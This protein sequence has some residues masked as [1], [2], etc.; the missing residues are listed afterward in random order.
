MRS[1][2]RRCCNHIALAVLQHKVGVVIIVITSAADEVHRSVDSAVLE[3]SAMTGYLGVLVGE[4]THVLHDGLVS[5]IDSHCYPFE[6]YAVVVKGV[7]HRQV[8]QIESGTVA[9][10]KYRIADIFSLSVEDDAITALTDKRYIVAGE[11]HQRFFSAYLLTKVVLTILDED[12]LACGCSRGIGCINIGEG[13]HQFIDSAYYVVISRL[14]HSFGRYLHRY[15]DSRVGYVTVLVFN[16]SLSNGQRV[17][18][19]VCQVPCREVER[20]STALS[21]Y[22]IASNLSG[23]IVGYHA[24]EGQRN[25]SVVVVDGNALSPLHRRGSRILMGSGQL[26][27]TQGLAGALRERE[28]NRL[29]RLMVL[30]RDNE[31]IR[32]TLVG[33]PAVVFGRDIGGSPLGGNGD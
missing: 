14:Y 33:V 30:Y 13:L 4:H 21:R 2:G 12:G 32:T 25:H 26:E 17:V 15:L 8:L 23:Y 7:L 5:S 16:C 31:V 29:T 3:I 24:V 6:G 19:C 28:R 22:R 10:V 18:R 9:Q 20:S 11:L 27:P 1:D